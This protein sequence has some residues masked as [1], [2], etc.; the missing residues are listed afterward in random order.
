[1]AGNQAGVEPGNRNKSS[2]VPLDHDKTTHQKG[3]R[4]SKENR[5]Q[6]E[7]PR[8]PSPEQTTK[9]WEGAHLSMIYEAPSMHHFGCAISRSGGWKNAK[10]GDD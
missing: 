2:R 3:P 6:T 9:Q 4:R 10:G 1:M 5:N 7:Y 8:Q